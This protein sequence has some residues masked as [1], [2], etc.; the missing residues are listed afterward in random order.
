[1][2]QAYKILKLVDKVNE[3]LLFLKSCGARGNQEKKNL[4]QIITQGVNSVNLMPQEPVNADSISRFRKR[5]DK[6][7]D[8]KSVNGTKRMYL[9]TF[10]I[11]V[12]AWELL[13]E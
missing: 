1:M 9:P 8:N 12:D 10:L 3:G 11:H 4:K 7:M 6:F 13:G 2:I 5:L